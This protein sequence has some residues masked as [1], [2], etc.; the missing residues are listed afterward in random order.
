MSKRD[1]E[2][3]DALFAEVL[4]GGGM[5]DGG[6][7][8]DP[9]GASR[10]PSIDP[11][12]VDAALG[13]MG[14]SW[15]GVAAMAWA[16]LTGEGDLPEWFDDLTTIGE[17]VR[18]TGK[19]RDEVTEALDM[20]MVMDGWRCSDPNCLTCRGAALGRVSPPST[21]T[22]DLLRDLEDRYVIPDSRLEEIISRIA[23]S[24]AMAEWLR[25]AGIAVTA[26][27]AAREEVVTTWESLCR[28]YGEE[29]RLYGQE[30]I[31]AIADELV[32]QGSPSFELTTLEGWRRATGNIPPTDWSWNRDQ[33]R[34]RRDRA[35]HESPHGPPQ[36][37][38]GR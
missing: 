17:I 14:A 2:A 31:G 36:R 25:R 27:E 37:R 7:G 22:L 4:D 1:D 10:D 12:S 26:W 32:D 6:Y 34:G 13:S 21:G 3:M 18:R 19:T 28:L 33:R 23:A 16:R 5:Q 11:G 8:P 24:T 29:E 20:S 35:G 15:V 30:I 9:N 38:R